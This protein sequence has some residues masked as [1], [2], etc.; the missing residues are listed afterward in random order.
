VVVEDDDPSSPTYVGGP[1]GVHPMP[2]I[3]TDKAVTEAALRSLGLMQLGRGLK[4]TEDVDL[5]IPQRPDLTYRHPV[6]LSRG[7][8][9]VAGVHEVSSWSLVMPVN[10]EPPQPMKVGMMRRYVR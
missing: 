2:S 10:G 5:T 4:P 6:K 1:W 8:V 3:E 7:L 9:G